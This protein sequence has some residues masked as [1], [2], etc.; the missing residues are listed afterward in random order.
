MLKEL[1]RYET[2]GTPRV[3]YELFNLIGENRQTWTPE[4]VKEYLFN[5]II[6][7]QSIFDGCMPLAISVGAITTAGNDALS[8]NPALQTTLAN[9]KYFNFRLLEIILAATRDDE[10]FHEIFNSKNI[11]FD[12]IYNH[13]QIDRGAFQFRYANFRHLLLSFSFIQEH[14]DSAIRKFIIHQKYRKLFDASL[15]PEIKKRKM[16][17]GQL[18]KMLAQ[19]QIY[20]KEAEEYVLEYER[21]R[22]DGHPNFPAIQIISPYDVGAGYD[23]ISFESHESRSHDR[24]IEVK[25]Y[26]GQPKFHWS[27]NEL[28]KARQLKDQYFLYLVNRVEMKGVDYEPLK[29][30]NPYEAVLQR[31]DSWEKRVEDFYITKLPD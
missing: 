26:A 5:R 27:R 9:Q 1:S 30:R 10:A 17:I 22:L 14:P 23:I 6:D 13:I 16:G 20:G 18:E 19:K 3:F 12:V 21:K 7:G 2:L 11:S 31:E 29:I 24:F 4:T 15:L 28:E 25:S 8:L